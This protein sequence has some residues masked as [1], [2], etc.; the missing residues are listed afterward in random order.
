MGKVQFFLT[1]CMAAL[2]FSLPVFAEAP[3]GQP[4]G[5]DLSQIGP[6]VLYLL[7]IV[8]VFYFILIRPQKKKDKE[9]KNMMDSLKKGDRIVTIGGFH[10]KILAVK[11]NVLTVQ[12]GDNKAKIENWAVKEV[13]KAADELDQIED[14]VAEAEE[15]ETDTEQQND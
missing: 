5:I 6:T 4:Q 3:A 7:V 12:F 13:T 10:G 1:A 8:A 2:G 15:A 11:N 9:Q 14:A